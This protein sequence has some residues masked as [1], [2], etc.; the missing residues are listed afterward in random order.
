MQTAELTTK[1]P[2]IWTYRQARRFRCSPTTPLEP[3]KQPC[4][5][6]SRPNNRKRRRP[7]SGR[8][9]NR[10]HRWREAGVHHKPDVIRSAP[11]ECD[12]IG[13]KVGGVGRRPLTLLAGFC[14]CS[15]DPGVWTSD[16]QGAGVRNSPLRKPRSDT[17]WPV[18]GTVHLGGTSAFQIP[19]FFLLLSPPTPVLWACLF[20][21]PNFLLLDL[22]TVMGSHALPSS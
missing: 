15:V 1:H 18:S 8:G 3:F 22:P 4:W 19:P 5:G 17:G 20:P 10:K 13:W 11:R 2:S 7:G 14:A 6:S 16:L 21:P 9:G 12:E